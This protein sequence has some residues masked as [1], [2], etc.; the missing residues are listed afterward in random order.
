MKNRFLLS[1]ALAFGCLSGL[2]TFSGEAKAETSLLDTDGAGL[3]D[4]VAR[5]SKPRQ[6]VD[7]VAARD[8]DVLR[9]AAPHDV[10]RERPDTARRDVVCDHARAGLSNRQLG[11]QLHGLAAG[12]GTGARPVQCQTG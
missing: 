6:D 7:G 3:S 4:G 10:V 5:A 1:S 11:A 12:R 2:A 9:Y 8:A